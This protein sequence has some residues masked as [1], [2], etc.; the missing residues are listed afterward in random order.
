MRWRG[1]DSS[2]AFPRENSIFQLLARSFGVS[3]PSKFYASYL[4]FKFLSGR[5]AWLKRAKTK[6]F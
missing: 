5:H 4:S 2:A 6:L 3:Q 1:R